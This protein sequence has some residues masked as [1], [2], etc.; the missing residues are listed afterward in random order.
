MALVIIDITTEIDYCTAVSCDYDGKTTEVIT[1]ISPQKRTAG[2]TVS[3][4]AIPCRSHMI[5]LI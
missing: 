2:E 1:I 3:P 5:S 4:T